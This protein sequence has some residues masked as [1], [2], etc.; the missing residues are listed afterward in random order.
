LLIGLAGACTCPASGPWD[1]GQARD[2]GAV[3]D[4]GA[5][6]DA[7]DAGEPG[8]GGLDGGVL[9][10]PCPLIKG[11]C[12]GAVSQLVGGQW[13]VCD[14]GPDYQVTERRCDGLDN[15]CDGRVDVSWPRV[16]LGSLDGGVLLSEGDIYLPKVTPL[17]TGLRLVLPNQ[18]LLV[19]DELLAVGIQ[20]FARHQ[21]NHSYLFR[22]GGDWLRLTNHY[23]VSTA[24]VLGE[25][26]L[27]DGGSFAALPDAGVLWRDCHQALG[28]SFAA[29]EFNNEW[30]T[31]GATSVVPSPEYGFLAW[32]RF[33]Q[34]GGFSTGLIDAGE[35][36]TQGS[37]LV[38]RGTTGLLVWSADSQRLRVA[39]IDPATLQLV[40]TLDV[41]QQSCFPATDG[42]LTY[43]C[44]SPAGPWHRE[45]HY[46]DG[47]LVTLPF[48]GRAVATDNPDG[49]LLAV[50][51]TN[52]DAGTVFALK[53]ALG[54]V[55]AGAVVQLAT[56]ENDP[57]L[58]TFNASTLGGRLVLAT[59]AEG[60]SSGVCPNCIIGSFNAAY[61]C[62]P[63]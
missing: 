43:E 53:L 11:I 19:D 59:W 54:A 17:A 25:R 31:L 23:D 10:R 57:I 1:G 35:I 62:L 45:W 20:T 26:I 29:I 2:G 44:Q 52:P 32:T 36:L 48:A 49:G 12:A 24:C 41:A 7:G 58:F 50:V 42:P 61:V 18:V 34:D 56:F 16:L 63:P 51:I 6:A 47:G 55:R 9:T 5:E 15:D 4:S 28:L 60:Y 22:L 33:R 21:Y 13:T 46:S 38:T 27:G 30:T 37:V 8:D 3:G 39:R 14:Y 40:D